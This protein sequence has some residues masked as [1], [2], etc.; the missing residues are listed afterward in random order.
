[1]TDAAK[2]VAI[3]VDGAGRTLLAVAMGA[4]G[5]EV[6]RRGADGWARTAVPD[7]GR[8]FSIMGLVRGS[9]GVLHLGWLRGWPNGATQHAFV[10]RLG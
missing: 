10:A 5:L 2:D 6:H 3:A 8:V 4:G 9:G 7:P 1:V